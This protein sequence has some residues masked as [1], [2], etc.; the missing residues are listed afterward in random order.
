MFL[1]GRAKVSLAEARS[2]L[3][4]TLRL[5]EQPRHGLAPVKTA[6]KSALAGVMK[7]QDRVDAVAVT[8]GERWLTESLSQ[9][10]T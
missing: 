7:A 2:T 9:G 10:N 6:L 1:R 5:F 8:E 3:E 4:D